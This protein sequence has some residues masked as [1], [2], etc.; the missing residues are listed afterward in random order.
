MDLE[1]VMLNEVSDRER[2][3]SYGFTYVWNLK[4][5]LNE[6]NKMETDSQRTN[7]WLPEE[8]GVQG[9]PKQLRAMKRHRPPVTK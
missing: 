7:R 9:G 6:Q 1:H 3:I 5:K 4:N 8:S 2:Q